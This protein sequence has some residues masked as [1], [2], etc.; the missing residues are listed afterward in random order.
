VEAASPSSKPGG[1]VLDERAMRIQL[2]KIASPGTVHR[3]RH[4]H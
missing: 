2:G 4:E 3:P 1:P